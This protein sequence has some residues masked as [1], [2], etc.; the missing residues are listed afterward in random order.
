MGELMLGKLFVQN[1]DG[2]YSEL[3]H[4][5]DMPTITDEIEPSYT[6]VRIDPDD[7]SITTALDRMSNRAIAELLGWKA[8]GPVRRRQWKKAL[9]MKPYK[10]RGQRIRE[11]GREALIQNSEFRIKN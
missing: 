10:T 2:S 9:W 7:Y 8:R 5:T 1:D 11:H 4:I 3:G 6:G